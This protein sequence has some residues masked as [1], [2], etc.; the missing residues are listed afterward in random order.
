MG[1]TVNASDEQLKS[2]ILSHKNALLELD[3]ARGITQGKELI[4]YCE[5]TPENEFDP[6]EYWMD[7]ESNLTGHSGVYGVVA[8]IMTNETKIRFG[9]YTDTECNDE[10]AIMLETCMPWHLNKKEKELTDEKLQAICEKYIAELNPAL[11][12]GEIRMEFFG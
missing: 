5:N 4:E 6:K 8:D 10:D 9:Y 12:Y 1:F 2:F 11:S 7:Y 3:F